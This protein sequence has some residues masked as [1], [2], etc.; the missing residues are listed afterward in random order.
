MAKKDNDTKNK[1]LLITA[2]V[3]GFRRGGIAHSINE[4]L[5][6][7]EKF[8]PEQLAQIRA[9]NGKNLLVKEVEVKGE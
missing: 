3:E 9:E 1:A 4:T 2:K 6:E 8:S 7:V 5:H